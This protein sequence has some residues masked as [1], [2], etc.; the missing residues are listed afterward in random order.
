[1]LMVALRWFG[2]GLLKVARELWLFAKANPWRA[3]AIAL[4]GVATWFWHG[5]S[6][7]HAK[8]VAIKAAQKQATADQVA[9]NHEPAR[10]SGEIARK[11]NAEAP[12]YYRRLGDAAATHAVRLSGRTR[13]IG[14]AGVPGADQAEPSLHRADVDPGSP[15]A[16][17]VCRPAADDSWLV[18]AAGRAAQM[19]AEAAAL[20]E[21]GAAVPEPIP[22]K[23]TP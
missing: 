23:G 4:A 3:N 7:D 15:G 22:S 17:L 9:I 14:P 10:V 1:M 16:D 19:Q 20:I 5:W 21:L 12:A 18:W 11:S 2:S 13:P 8:L 6:S